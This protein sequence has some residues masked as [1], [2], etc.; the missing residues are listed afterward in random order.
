MS[1][2]QWALGYDKVKQKDFRNLPSPSGYH[3]PLL[4]NDLFVNLWIYSADSTH[5]TTFALKC[6]T[7]N[8]SP[9]AI[10]RL[11]RAPHIAYSQTD[12]KQSRAPDYK[13]MS[14]TFKTQLLNLE[15]KAQEPS[16]MCLCLSFFYQGISRKVNVFNP[17][18]KI[19][20]TTDIIF[21]KPFSFICL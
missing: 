19:A 20:L 18:S 12:I 10:S 1:S 21:I 16:L 8:Y 6:K 7:P 9:G 15:R 5:F 11:P 14:F 17:F 13:I 2:L 3:D 4:F